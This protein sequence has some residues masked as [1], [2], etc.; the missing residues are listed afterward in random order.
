MT[1]IT[2]QGQGGDGVS[3]R[4]YWAS[5]RGLGNITP[6][7]KLWP[8]GESFPG[9]LAETF[10]GLRTVEFG[11]GVGRLAQCFDPKLYVGVDICPDAV[12]IARRNNPQHEFWDADHP[13][14]PDGDIL[15]AHTV[16]LHIPDDELPRWAAAFQYPRVVVSEIL[17]RKWRRPGN[18]PV[19]NR[20][21]DEYVSVFADAGYMLGA[22]RHVPYPH[23]RDTDLTMLTFAR[24]GDA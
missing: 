20:E 4:S 23:Y 24:A 18:P 16:L 14:M 11:C 12:A 3:P 19:F 17:G 21:A 9:I 10:R 22:V 1:P 15:L 5:G 7:G 8:E 6:A 13:Q 2:Q